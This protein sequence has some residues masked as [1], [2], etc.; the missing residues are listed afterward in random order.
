LQRL[1]G[2]AEPRNLT[3]SVKTSGFIG[4]G[5]VWTT[6]SEILVRYFEPYSS[7]HQPRCAAR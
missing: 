1:C 6:G 2:A 3:T 4:L 5:L 7:A